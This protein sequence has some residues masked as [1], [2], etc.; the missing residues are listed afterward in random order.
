MRQLVALAI[1]ITLAAIGNYHPSAQA[2]APIYQLTEVASGF[3]CPLYVTHAGDG[4]GRLFVVEQGGKIWTLTNGVISSEVFLDVSNLISPSALGGGY[5]EQGLLGLAFHPDFSRN[6]V[7]FINYTDQSGGSV[8]ARYAVAPDNPDV[9]DPGS[10]EQILSLAQP[11]RNHNGGHM[12]FGPDGYLYVS[13]GDGGSGGDPQGY[14]QNLTTLL[15]KILRLDVDVEPGQGY[16][17]PEDNPFA[18]SDA[19]RPE[20]WAWGLRNVWRFSFDRETGDMFLGDVGQNA[21][22]EINFQPATSAGGENYGWNAYEATRAFSGADP[23]SDVVM[24]IL[25]YNHSSG[26]CSVTG[27]YVYRGN[28][29]PDLQG[30]YFYGDYCSGTIWTARSDGAGNWQ[31]EVSMES[32]RPISSFGEDEAG[33]LYLVDYNGAIL[34]FEP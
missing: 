34:R 26:H 27:G 11:Y 16:A 12:A 33:E 23:A 29:L 2:Q 32:R 1:A 13:F 14:G 18:N 30:A 15:G 19:A 7:F 3:N 22:E 6:G 21:W 10:A 4:S 31:S 24:P 20:I 9:A 17:I 25:E 28:L 8:I 5:T